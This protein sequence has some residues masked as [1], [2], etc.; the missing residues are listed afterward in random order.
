VCEEA[1]GREVSG[2]FET[3]VSAAPKYSAGSTLF[4]PLSGAFMV[5][6]LEGYGLGIRV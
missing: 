1:A 6:G 2:C 3:A 4:P 5:K